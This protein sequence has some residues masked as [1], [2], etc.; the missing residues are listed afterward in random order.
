MRRVNARWIS[1]AVQRP[2]GIS[3]DLW[4]AITVTEMTA[5]K[6]VRRASPASTLECIML[7]RDKNISTAYSRLSKFWVRLNDKRWLIVKFLHMVFLCKT[8]ARIN[9]LWTVFTEWKGYSDEVAPDLHSSGAIVD[10]LLLI[11]PTCVAEQ[12]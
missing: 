8:R 1:F 6:A 5:L 4:R 9:M 3:L 2:I 7:M 10:L 12:G 11:V